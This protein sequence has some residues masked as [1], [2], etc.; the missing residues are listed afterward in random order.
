MMMGTLRQFGLKTQRFGCPILL[1]SIGAVVLAVTA[2]EWIRFSSFPPAYMELP[3]NRRCVLEF[4]HWYSGRYVLSYYESGVC[5]GTVR[6]S[7][8]ILTDPLAFFPGPDGNT[9]LCL[10]WLDVTNAAFTVDFTKRNLRGVKIPE[11]LEDAVDWS[12]FEVRACTHHEVD[13]TRQYLS[14]VDRGTLSHLVRDC[15]D[16]EKARQNMLRFLYSATTPN[17]YG[18]DLNARAQIAPEN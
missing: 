16:P 10:S 8:G 7:G 6:L 17:L 11:R 3:G 18:T 15:T 1:L 14:A 13:F 4:H 5:T 2:T 12:T 9:V